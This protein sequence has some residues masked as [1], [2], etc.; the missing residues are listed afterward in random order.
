MVL[1]GDDIQGM[2]IINFIGNVFENSF[3]HEG[4]ILDSGVAGAFDRVVSKVGLL[5][6]NT[7]PVS[8]IWVTLLRGER[9]IIDRVGI[10]EID[11]KFTW[12]MLCQ[13]PSSFAI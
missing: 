6:S 9:A 1:L 4:W 8:T 10:M 13:F 5:K 7:K 3:K 12:I 11:K 2:P